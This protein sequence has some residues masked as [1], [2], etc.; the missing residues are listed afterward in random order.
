MLSKKSVDGNAKFLFKLIIQLMGEAA[1][2]M[3]SK[4]E[5]I[6]TVNQ[7]QKSASF[8]GV[9]GDNAETMSTDTKVR[10]LL[11]NL[12]FSFLYRMR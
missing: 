10:F 7:L 8:M 5:E 6:N 9:Y 4:I 1:K 11:Q 3:E 2:A 12:K